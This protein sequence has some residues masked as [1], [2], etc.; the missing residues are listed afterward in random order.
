MP[1]KECMK[2]GK[3]GYRWGSSGRCYTYTKGDKASEAEALR[4]AHKQERAIYATGWKEK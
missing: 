3:Q 2:D 1:V 4:K